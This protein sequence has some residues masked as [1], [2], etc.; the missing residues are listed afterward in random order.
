MSHAGGNIVL[1]AGDDVQ[2]AV[3]VYD[4]DDTPLGLEGATVVWAVAERDAAATRVLT[5][6]SADGG[7]VLGEPS[8]RFVIAIAAADTAGLAGRYWH[9]AQVTDGAGNRSTVLAGTLNVLPTIIGGG[10]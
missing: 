8:N 7:I 4:E 10:E 3:D 5:K 1:H 9:Q 6:S 2:I